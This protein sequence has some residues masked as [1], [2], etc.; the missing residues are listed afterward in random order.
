MR[1]EKTAACGA[2][3]W[4]GW[5]RGFNW[6]QGGAAKAASMLRHA[7]CDLS[8]RVAGLALVLGIHKCQLYMQRAAMVSANHII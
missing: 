6:Q 1:L 7:G 8:Y 3:R 5:V 2:S 4:A